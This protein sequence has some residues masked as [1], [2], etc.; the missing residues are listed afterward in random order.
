VPHAHGFPDLESEESGLAEVRCEERLGLAFVT[1]EGGTPG[2]EHALVGL[3]GL[4]ASE[5]RLL[6]SSAAEIDASWKI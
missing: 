1:Q 4:V 5:Q 2:A 6:A 3:P